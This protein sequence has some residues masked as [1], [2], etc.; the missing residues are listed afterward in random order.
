VVP[1]ASVVMAEAQHLVPLVP[2]VPVARAVLVVPVDSD[3]TLSVQ[4]VR[5]LVSV[6]WVAWAATVA[7]PRRVL[8]ASVVPVGGAAMVARAVLVESPEAEALAELVV[9]A[10]PEA[11]VASRFLV[12]AVGVARAV[13]AVMVVRVVP[14]VLE[15]S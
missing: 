9:W 8:V 11:M 6:A 14:E 7:Q 13:T 1:V 10:H 3:S 4:T 15:T 2:E 5:L 12:S